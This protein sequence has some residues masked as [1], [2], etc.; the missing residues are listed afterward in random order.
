MLPPAA[1][2]A[3]GRAQPPQCKPLGVLHRNAYRVYHNLVLR[4]R[5]S[6]TVHCWLFGYRPCDA[7]NEHGYW[8]WTTL[9]LRKAIQIY[10]RPEMSLLDVGTGPVAVLAVFAKL[11]KRCLRVTGV[12]YVP[13]I[14]SLAQSTAQHLSLDIEVRDSDL[15]SEVAG[16]FDMIVFNAP[17]LDSERGRQLGILRRGLDEKR[18]RG[19][20]GGGNTIQRFLDG[21]P[22]HLARNGIAVVGVN[23]YHITRTLVM[24]LI[25]RSGLELRRR[26]EG[27]AIPAAA[28]VL[29]CP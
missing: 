9:I 27:V 22:R 14:V 16:R 17:Y 18:F 2:N 25:A 29:R 19:G 26:I 12:D 21:V 23:H 24:A 5:R 6:K 7:S 15:F 4:L 11:Q 10:L 8:D 1:I 13:E 28:Y 20:Q 3:S